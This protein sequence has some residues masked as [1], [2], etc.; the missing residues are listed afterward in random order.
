MTSFQFC[1]LSVKQALRCGEIKNDIPLET[2]F[3]R[4]DIHMAELNSLLPC[5]IF[6]GSR[7]GSGVATIDKIGSGSKPVIAIG[8]IDEIDMI[9]A[10][11]VGSRVFRLQGDV[12]ISSASPPLNGAPAEV[13]TPGN[14]LI[15]SCP[16]SPENRVGDHDSCTCGIQTASGSAFIFHNGQ[17][18]QCCRAVELQSSSV[19]LCPILGKQ[20]VQCRETGIFV[21]RISDGTAVLLCCIRVQSR[22]RNR[23]RGIFAARISD[24]TAILLCS[25]GVQ[26]RVR[27]RHRGIS[28]PGEADGTA[29]L[30]CSIGVQGRG[31]NCYFGISS[32]VESNSTAV[33]GCVVQL[34]VSL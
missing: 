2:G 24:G 6:L 34:K 32:S 8:R 21:A 7:N 4:A 14:L 3:I 12:M 23:H 29:I 22:V 30:L 15:Q 16:V 28:N 11:P 20:R 25:I 31:G 19:Y 27:N 33:T 9:N 1:R 13:G 5:Q 26:S 18:A 10:T 17:V